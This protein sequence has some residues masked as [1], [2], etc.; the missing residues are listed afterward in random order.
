MRKVIIIS[1]FFLLDFVQL[2]AQDGGGIAEVGGDVGENVGET[3][4]NI[5][6]IVSPSK[7]SNLVYR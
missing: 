5:V 7:I 3:F 1:V 6:E 2:M 4:T